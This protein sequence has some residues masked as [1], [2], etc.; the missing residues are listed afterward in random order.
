MTFKKTSKGYIV[1]LFKGEKIVESLT[2]FCEDENIASG[3]FHGIGAVLQAEIGLYNLDKKQYSFTE[4][5]NGMELVSMTGN[6]ALVDSKPF[7]HI[8]VVLADDNKKTFGGHLKEG[9]VG[10]TCEIY[11]FNFEEKIKREYDEEIG[12]KLLNLD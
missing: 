3:I 10:P 8:H 7:L 2:K 5:N 12:L 9:I 1:R 4:F 11:I 6:V